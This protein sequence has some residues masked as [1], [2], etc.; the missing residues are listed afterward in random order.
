MVLAL[1]HEGEEIAGF[2]I[3]PGG[4]KRAVTYFWPTDDFP[5]TREKVSLVKGGG[6]R[7]RSGFEPH[8]ATPSAYAGFRIEVLCDR[9]SGKWRRQAVVVATDDFKAMLAHTALQAK[10]RGLA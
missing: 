7:G 10:L 2:V 3:G 6:A 1:G 4:S 9:V 5:T 8:D